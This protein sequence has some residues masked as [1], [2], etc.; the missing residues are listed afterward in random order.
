MSIQSLINWL[1]PREDHF[2]DFLE[3]QAQVAQRAVPVLGRFVHSGA[4][5]EAIRV[6][7]TKIEKEGDR[8]VDEVLSA[9]SDTFVTPIYR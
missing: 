6:E 8:I 1:L 2:Y 7:V 3:R 5:Y 9:L 4:D